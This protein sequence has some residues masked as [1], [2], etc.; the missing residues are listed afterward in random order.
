MNSNTPVS[1]LIRV[2]LI[3][4]SLN[5]LFEFLYSWVTIQDNVENTIFIVL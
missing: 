3:S 1:T 4:C 5:I 2:L